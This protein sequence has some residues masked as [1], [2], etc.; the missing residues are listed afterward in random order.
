[1]TVYR[2][3]QELSDVVEEYLQAGST[4]GKIVPAWDMNKLFNGDY[5][6]HDLSPYLIAR[7]I[8]EWHAPP[9]EQASLHGGLQRVMNLRRAKEE[10][11]EQIKARVLQIANQA[12][13]RNAA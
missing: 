6:R 13:Q 9:P 7:H 10:E 12:Y 8:I 1:M 2:T 5:D 3:R 4:S 11:R